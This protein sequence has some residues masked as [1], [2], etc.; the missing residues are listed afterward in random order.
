MGLPDEKIAN[1]ADPIEWLNYFPSLGEQDLRLFGLH[2][3]WRRSFITSDINPFYD[4]F[5]RW[6]FARLRNGG[7]IDFGRRATIYSPL[8]EQA[9]A[10]HD[11]SSGEGVG[12]QEYTLIKLALLELPESAAEPRIRA[13]LEAGKLFMVAATLRPETMYGQTNCFVLPGGEYGAYEFNVQIAPGSEEREK[14]VLICSERAATN[15]SYQ[16]PFSVMQGWGK[17]ELLGKIKGNELI[18]I[19]VKAPKT[20]YER[21]YCLPLLTISMNKGTGIV[22]SVPSDSPDD[23]A[24]LRD[25]Q[26]DAKLRET[27]GVTEEMVAPFKVLP[28]IEIPKM[29]DK[30]AVFMCDK[31]KVKSQNDK[32]KLEEAKKEAYK[33]GFYK[34]IMLVG[35][36]DGVKGM[37][38]YEAKDVCK[39]KMCAKGEAFTYYEPE[40]EVVARSGCACVVAYLDQWF[41]KYGEPSWAER[42]RGHIKDTANFETYTSATRKAFTEVVDW[43]KEWACSRN[44]GLGTLVPFDERFVIESLSDSTIYMAYYTI[45]HLLQGRKDSKDYT[46]DGGKH[47]RL[48]IKPEQLVPE[49]FDYIF[50]SKGYPPDC[51]IEQAKL[52]KLRESFEYW[53]P[54]NLRVS[55]RDLVQNHLAM[56]LYNHAAIWHERPEMMPRGFY[57]NGKYSFS[58]LLALSSTNWCCIW[59]FSSCPCCFLDKGCDGST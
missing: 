11:R 58:C 24:A 28:I 15:M 48:G 23:Y 59:Y 10:D 51:G 34:G 17:L 21:V 41:I 25:W 55:G 18:G 44:F 47:S 37:T 29:G 46:G 27:H 56:L 39:T 54:M 57:V 8:D 20:S 12:P 40:Q 7:K 32:K 6:Q 38:V 49:V 43:L 13:A 53:Y 36:A 42:V 52:D 45:A 26:K 22:T 2:T 31:F 30:S 3:D 33:G 9:C 4:Q 5:I 50:L 16:D 35:E 14:Q 19:P 1:F